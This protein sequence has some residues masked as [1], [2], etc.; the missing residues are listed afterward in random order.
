MEE[1]RDDAFDKYKFEDG[2]L[3]YRDL[4]Y[5]PDSEPIKVRILQ[6]AH[7]SV[8][9]AHPGQAKTLEI[10]QRDFFWPKM[11]EFI[12]EYI[13]SCDMCQRAKA[14]H[15][16][17]YGLLQNLP[18]P[19]GPWRSLSMDHIT[20]LPESNGFNCIL[21]VCCRL[22]KQAVFIPTRK[23]DTSRDLA[24]QFLR[25]IFRL[26]GLPTDIVSDRGPTF[27]SG[28]WRAFVSQLKVKPNVS[29]AFYP[30]TDGQTERIHQSLEL[31]LRVFS[32][33]LQDNWF[34]LLPFA[35]FAYNSTY[36]SSIGMTPFFANYGYHPRMS[37]TIS[38]SPVPD[39]DRRIQEMHDTHD[40]A[41]A[42]ISK[43][44]EQHT[45]WANR[46]RTPAPDFAVGDK[47]WLLRR[48]IKTS[49]PSS[50]LD[51]KKLGPFKITEKIGKLAFRLQLPT[52]MEVHD[53]FHVSLLEKFVPNRFVERS[54]PDPPAPVVRPDGVE[55]YVVESILNSRI[56]RGKLDYF[57]HWQGYPIEDRSW[58]WASDLNDDDAPVIAFHTKY[59]N[60]PGYNRIRHSRRARA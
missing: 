22:T 30:E 59:P 33:Y 11:R 48:H 24:R 23:S 2:L 10:I 31:H 8:E 26:H 37:I 40:L 60:K 49:R 29:T 44:L 20:D 58:M 50:K 27:T 38:S 39:A 45:L 1:D 13:R 4:I 46:R 5:V 34:E 51:F 17:K 36:H 47:V 42:S 54:L 16:S 28:W 18:I 56:T 9:V 12:N 7:D 32:D 55:T 35:E 43:A 52:T 14:V 53:V 19:T 57:V 21:V 25:E 15:H 41:K 6:S 3:L